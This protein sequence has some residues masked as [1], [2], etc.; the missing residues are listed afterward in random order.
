VLGHSQRYLPPPTAVLLTKLSV[1]DYQGNPASGS[2]RWSPRAALTEAIEAILAAGQAGGGAGSS[3]RRQQRG[4]KPAP[5]VP[6]PLIEVACAGSIAL[7]C[8]S[9]ST[10]ATLLSVR[11]AS[12]GASVHIHGM[13]HPAFTVLHMPSAADSTRSA[14]ASDSIRF[15]GCLKSQTG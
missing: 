9:C 5:R 6:P 11:S 1:S 14:F 12:H 4:Q 3:G 7:L 13:I 8:E 10:L 15:I 2:N